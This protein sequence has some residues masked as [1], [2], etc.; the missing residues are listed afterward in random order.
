MSYR[1]KFSLGDVVT[2][3]H[4][5]KTA[6]ITHL[7]P[8]DPNGWGWQSQ[9]T[10]KYEQ[11]GASFQEQERY[12]KLQE[13]PSA[14]L[15][16]M[17]TLYSFTKPDGSTGYGT[18][19]AT[20]S[21]NQL[22]IEEKGTGAI[23]TFDKEQLEEVLP[24]TFAVKVNGKE[25]HYLG[26]SSSTLKKGDVVMLTDANSNYSIGKVTGVDTKNRSPRE[27]FNG[28]KLVTEPI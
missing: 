14:T 18:Y 16:N 1:F 24:Y 13:S 12:L 4:G 9:Y 19:L 11:S 26:N 15:A 7:P 6:V 23:L 22:I 20:N 17:K 21:T 5:K 28:V 25:T 27:K 10:C 8:G 3:A 2:K